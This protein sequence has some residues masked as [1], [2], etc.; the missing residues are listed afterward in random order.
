VLDEAELA[1]LTADIDLSTMNLDE[2]QSVL[3]A[4]EPDEVSQ[5]SEQ[6]VI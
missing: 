3:E 6:P 4:A 2:I 1:A 5:L